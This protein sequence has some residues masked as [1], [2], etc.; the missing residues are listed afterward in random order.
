[1]KAPSSKLRRMI[2]SVTGAYRVDPL[3]EARR[4]DRRRGHQRRLAALL[5]GPASTAAAAQQQGGQRH[6]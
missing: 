4:L 2:R 1:M 3:D 6:P 5:A